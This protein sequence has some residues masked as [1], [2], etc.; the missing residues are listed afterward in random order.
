MLCGPLRG[1]EKWDPEHVFKAIADVLKKDLQQDWPKK[2]GCM[3]CAHVSLNHR[4][5]VATSFTN[6]VPH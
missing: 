6:I 1:L 3:D 2:T 4:K 5:G